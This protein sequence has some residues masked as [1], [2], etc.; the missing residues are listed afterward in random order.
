M[1]AAEPPIPVLVFSAQE[2]DEDIRIQVSAAFVK[3]RTDEKSLVRAIRS[4][5]EM[6]GTL[7]VDQVLIDP[8]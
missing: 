3:S 4:S 8:K 5:L 6:A 7:P 1:N 2:V